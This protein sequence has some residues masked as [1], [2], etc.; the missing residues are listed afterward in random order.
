MQQPGFPFIS[1]N[2]LQIKAASSPVKASPDSSLWIPLGSAHLSTAIYRLRGVIAAPAACC[3]HRSCHQPVAAQGSGSQLQALARVWARNPEPM[4]RG[5][6]GWACETSGPIQLIKG[7]TKPH[8]LNL[9]NG[10][11]QKDLVAQMFSPPD[12]R[13]QIIQSPSSLQ[14]RILRG[15][16]AAGGGEC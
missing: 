13:I 5:R 1:L 4:G 16:C 12:L 8:Q 7:R 3:L 15:V 9:A 10:K 14:G 2:V 11:S 6:G